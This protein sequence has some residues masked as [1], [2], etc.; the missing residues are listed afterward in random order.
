MSRPMLNY[1]IISGAVLLYFSIIVYVPTTNPSV[2]LAVTKTIPWLL[3]LGF[4]LC[5][6]TIIMKMF[7]VYYIV[8]DPLPNK[9]S[10]FYTV[11]RLKSVL[12]CHYFLRIFMTG[13]LLLEFLHLSS[14]TLSF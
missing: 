4:S 8:N 12:Q 10:S 6:G 2:F 11:L 5:Y 14:L 7:R 3:A 13:H 1:L 9:V